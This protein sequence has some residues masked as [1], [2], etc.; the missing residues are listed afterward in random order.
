MAAAAQYGTR[1]RRGRHR[2]AS[3][4]ATGTGRLLGRRL[5]Q[6]VAALVSASLLVAMGYYRHTY[7]SLDNGLHRI[8]IG[9]L[10]RPT[11]APG[12]SVRADAQ[13]RQV[14]G[15]AQ[16]LLIIG[17]DSRAGLSRAEIQ[18]LH[19]G[20]S[21]GTTSTDTLLVVHVPADGSRATLISIPRDSYVDIPGFQSNKINAAYVDGYTYGTDGYPVDGSSS[22]QQR[23][24][25][26]LTLL[27][28]VIKNLTGLEI[29]HYVMVNFLGFY[30]IAQAIGGIPVN[31]CHA[32]D[33]TGAYNQAHGEGAV[34]SGFQMSAGHHDLTPL[35]SLEFVRQRHNL[36]DSRGN[37]LNDIGREARQRYFLGAAFA[38]IESAGTLIHPGTLSSLV[39]ALKSTLILDD[40]LSLQSLAHQMLDLT[41]G[42]I[43]GQTIPTRGGQTFPGVGDALVVDVPAVQAQI[44]RW[45]SPPAATPNSPVTGSP[46]T[47]GTATAG[48]RSAVAVAPS[49]SGGVTAVATGKCIN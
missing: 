12:D 15:A 22:D 18:R 26:G 19:V 32:V 45:L 36:V 21:D 35:Q 49:N 14:D 9:G 42:N 39:D 29:D 1:H 38:K 3:S 20:A 24:A 2:C 8:A 43:V 41:G 25:A 13:V 7:T 17:S 48:T 11:A 34:G 28:R 40:G 6:V 47:R 10:G 23:Q 37:Q 27:I 16:N 30:N 46:V 31:L 33:D 4:A 5:L 44:Q